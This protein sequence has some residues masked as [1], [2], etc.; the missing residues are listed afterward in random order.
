MLAP[1]TTEIGKLSLIRNAVALNTSLTME[2]WRC[3]HHLRCQR[4]SS[5]VEDDPFHPIKYGT[6]LAD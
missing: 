2:I 5:A 3:L 1:Y 4:S 6:R